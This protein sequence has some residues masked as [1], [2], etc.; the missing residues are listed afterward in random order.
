M[1]PLEKVTLY[2]APL[3][4]VISVIWFFYTL[5]RGEFSWQI[6]KREKKDLINKSK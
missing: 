3:V 1:V 6:R 4:V 2:F 5:I